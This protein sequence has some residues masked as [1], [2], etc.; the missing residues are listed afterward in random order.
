MNLPNVSLEEARSDYK[1]CNSD[2]EHM[3]SAVVHLKQLSDKS[4]FRME[5]YR[6]ENLIVR[7][8]STR[9]KIRSVIERLD[10]GS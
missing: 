6:L 4:A 2:I 7:E 9:E 3:R 5:V 8:V 10:N 1:T